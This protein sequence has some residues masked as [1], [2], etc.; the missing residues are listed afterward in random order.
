MPSRA[1]SRTSTTPQRLAPRRHPRT[2][3]I[4][5]SIHWRKRTSQSPV[6]RVGIY[7]VSSCPRSTRCIAAEIFPK[8]LPPPRRELAGSKSPKSNEWNHRLRPRLLRKRKRRPSEKVDQ[9]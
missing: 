1:L 8:S 2:N 3:P 5:N 7:L 6:R 4:R 9:T